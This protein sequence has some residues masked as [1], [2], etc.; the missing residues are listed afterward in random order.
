MK[1]PRRQPKALGNS[2][3][4]SLP[5]HPSKKTSGGINMGLFEKFFEKGKSK[6]FEDAYEGV[7]PDYLIEEARRKREQEEREEE[8]RRKRKEREEER[9]RQQEE[10]EFDQALRLGNSHKKKDGGGLFGGGW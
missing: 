6:A 8:E 2:S 10:D 4:N 9:R 5:H 7:L 1:T 3:T